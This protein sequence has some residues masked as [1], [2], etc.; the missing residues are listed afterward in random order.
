LNK[1]PPDTTYPSHLFEKE[2][3][4]HKGE[5][6]ETS[7]SYG[8]DLY[9]LS[10]A[11]IN[12][13]TEHED[14]PSFIVDRIDKSLKKDYDYEIG[15]RDAL[16]HYLGAQALAEE[17]GPN[18]SEF[19]GK[20]HEGAYFKSELGNQARIDIQNNAKALEDFKA[21]RKLKEYDK[22]ILDSLLEEITVPPEPEWFKEA[23]I[24]FGDTLTVPGF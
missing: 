17:Y 12:K 21:N 24:E 8:S 20:F 11:L 22:S 6:L 15:E 9:N 7:P 14:A 10:R 13:L 23:K 19:I 5:W 4:G 16:R 3:A 18:I 2:V 1:L